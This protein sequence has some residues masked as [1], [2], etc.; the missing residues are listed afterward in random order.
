MS[1]MSSADRGSGISR[2][3]VEV[4]RCRSTTAFQDRKRSVRFKV[5]RFHVGQA[6]DVCIA[7]LGGDDI[8]GQMLAQRTRRPLRTGQTPATQ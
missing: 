3:L 6:L 2:R 8:V 5:D 4:R 7:S 1:T